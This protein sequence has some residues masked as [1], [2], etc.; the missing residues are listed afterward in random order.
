MTDTNESPRAETES[1]GSDAILV[2][3]AGIGGM[4][5][6]LLLAD[7]GYQVYLLDSAPGIGGSM[8]LLDRTFPTDS[9]G[10]CLMLPGRAAYCPTI[11]CDLHENV[12]IL[13]YSEVGG[14]AGEPGNFTVSV[15]RKPRYVDVELCNNCGRCAQVCPIERPHPYEGNIAPQKAIYQP[16]V[17]AIPS[18]Y[19]IDMDYCTR[20]GECVAECPVDAIDLDMAEHEE[21]IEVGAVV[22]SP[23]YEP[24][25][26]SVKGEY[27]FGHY[28]NV[29]SSIQFE[30]MVSLSGSTGADIV[31]PSDG[32]T[33][34][35]IAFIQCVGSRDPSID[36]GYCS[37]VCCMY[38]A[39]QV[40]VAKKL[41]PDIDVTVFFMDIRAHGKD[42]DEYFD[43]VEATP[44]VNYRRA[45]VS[46]IHEYKQTGDVWVNFV[47]E[48][49]TVHEEDFDM[50]VLAVGFE[51]P[52]GFQDLGRA[53]GV[54]L[55][56]YGFGVTSTFHPTESSQPGILISGAFREPKDIP[57]TVVEASAV[58]A[59]AA[60]LVRRPASSSSEQAE[61]VT[62][63]GN[64]TKERDVSLEWPRVGVFLCDCRGEIGSVV[65]LEELAEYADDLRDVALVQTMDNAC[66]LSGRE[67]IKE[68]I[69]EA[70]L[71][72]VVI[73]GCPA[74][75]YEAVFERLMR[76]VGLNPALLER[77]N[78]R[79]EIAWVHQGNGKD[80]TAKAKNLLRMAAAG[81]RM[82]QA[83]HFESRE[84]S[85]RA[86]VIGGGLAGMTAALSLAEMGHEVDLVERSSE[87]GGQLRELRY[88]LTGEDPVAFTSSLVDE[89]K[90]HDRIHVYR[91]AEVEDVTGWVGQ[92]ETTVALG[93]EESEVLTHGAIVV[94]TGGQEVTPTE[95]LYGEDPHVVTQR[96]LE[97]M[98]DADQDIPSDVVM[99]QCV[100][101]RE[102]E[103]P[104]CSRICCTKAVTN[105]LQIKER[106]PDSRVFV[107]YREMRT[108]GFREDIYEEARQKGVIFLR[109]ELP[110]KPQVAAGDGGLG[111]QLR[112]PVTG[113]DVELHAGML[114]LS[115]GIEPN[116]VEGLARMLGV[117]L[118]K[119]GF[120]QEE[121]PK[122]RPLDFTK[123]G[124]FMCGLA[125]SPRFAD[126]TI[127]QAQGA[128][129]RA[130]ALLKQQ[131]LEAPVA[132]VR[133]NERLCTACGQCVEVC[134]YDARVLEPGAHTAEV[135]EVLCQGC[136]AC[137][138]AC[139]NKA[140]RRQGVT[141]P[142][143][144]RMLDAVTLES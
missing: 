81:V 26:A 5:S 52:Q 93:E 87:L 126:E 109:Y 139:P 111:I 120:F 31:R 24:F 23:G 76:D 124:I 61:S 6:A 67:Q 18:T 136:G 66:L 46:S 96:E 88:L 8:H 79:G 70:E 28:D 108:Y 102:P 85:Q 90:G 10:I 107:L 78:L 127:V 20:C 125:H 142:S 14:V 62:Q 138:V 104:Y 113:E 54:D 132:P 123:R 33:P 56:K 84:L 35:R 97:K 7:A 118:D 63:T 12:R 37:S 48:D 32:E 131:T 117:P 50:V 95:Y 91:E 36:R 34:R 51:P 114:V 16:P 74:R 60:R 22:M 137:I 94:A 2:V 29:L 44:G 40:Q 116:D 92:Y 105:A 41:D 65:D 100:G 82:D 71:N 25:D 69:E 1:V 64:G 130:A 68:A 119:N 101:S 59:S 15:R 47:G 9:C 49:G 57:E 98:L 19:V 128:A 55:N 121:Y 133:V 13:P 11:E 80:A 112:E 73:A 39:K 83:V 21:Q 72:R 4:Q 3:G 103:R 140:T 86:L 134:P 38:T 75:E 115:N 89:V 143:V 53:L 106:N 43:E 42:F 27:G 122:M 17:R 129:M 30:R 110:D 135:I 77:V 99:I 58:A 141:V 45:M 144:Y